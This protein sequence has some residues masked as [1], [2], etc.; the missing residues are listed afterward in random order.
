MS[1]A[2]GLVEAK[3]LLPYFMESV[4]KARELPLHLISK[5]NSGPNQMADKWSSILENSN[6]GDSAIIDVN[7]WLGNAALD[8]CV[9]VSPLGVRGLQTNLISQGSALELSITTSARWTKLI[10]L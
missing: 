6:S 7:M 9:L 1:P 10:T 8:A 4:T 3:G 2:F 5:A